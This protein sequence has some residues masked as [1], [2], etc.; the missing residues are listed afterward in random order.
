[1]ILNKRNVILMEP[2]TETSQVAKLIAEQ[3][4]KK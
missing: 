2:V 4:A 1:M 3:G